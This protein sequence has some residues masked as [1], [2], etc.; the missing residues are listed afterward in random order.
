MSGS[1]WDRFPTTALVASSWE[2]QDWFQKLCGELSPK[3]S[4][5]FQSKA[6]SQNLR[7]GRGGGGRTAESGH[8]P[9]TG[10]FQLVVQR[11]H[12]CAKFSIQKEYACTIVLDNHTVKSLYLGSCV[13]MLTQH[14]TKGCGL[15]PNTH[16]LTQ[17]ALH[18]KQLLSKS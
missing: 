10:V 17:H 12:A 4:K 2:L 9:V 5:L 14:H 3:E 15:I 8:V 1:L 6:P 7:K 11:I 18:H 13:E 16:E